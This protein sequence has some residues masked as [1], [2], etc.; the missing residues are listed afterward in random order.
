MKMERKDN[1]SSNL[2]LEGF[3]AV[4]A[5]H[6]FSL[7][8]AKFPQLTLCKMSVEIVPAYR[9]RAGENSHQ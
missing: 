7:T 9:I 5:L 8:L 2:A 3:Y 1:L 6:T 4:P